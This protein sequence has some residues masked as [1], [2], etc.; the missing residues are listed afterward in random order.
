MILRTLI[1]F[2][3]RGSKGFLPI[4]VVVKETESLSPILSVHPNHPP[5]K[6]R[7]RLVGFFCPF[8]FVTHGLEVIVTIVTPIV[9]HDKV[10]CACSC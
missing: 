6:C 5:R 3:P 9:T 4:V 7:S 10:S 8:P 2:V 1:V